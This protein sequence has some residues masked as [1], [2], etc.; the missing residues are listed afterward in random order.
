M[1]IFSRSEPDDAYKK[2]A[3]KKK[4]VYSDKNDKTFAQNHIDG[5]FKADKGGSSLGYEFY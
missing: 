2:N 1:L 4:S 5:K 3:Y